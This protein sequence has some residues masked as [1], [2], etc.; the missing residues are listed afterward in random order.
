MP[1]GDPVPISQSSSESP[2]TPWKSHN[3]SNTT[4]SK[5]ARRRLSAV[6]L[7]HHSSTAFR[8]FRTPGRTIPPEANSKKH[9]ERRCQLDVSRADQ[10][11]ALGE[12][13]GKS[14]KSQEKKH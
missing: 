4:M 7:R 9:T 2:S 3:K 10:P 1:I 5:S 13:G 12:R 11:H 8:V 14:R 6:Q